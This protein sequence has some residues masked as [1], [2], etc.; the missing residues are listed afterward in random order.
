M[1]IVFILQVLQTSPYHQVPIECNA[2]YKNQKSLSYTPTLLSPPY[3][4]LG[5]AFHQQSPIA[6]LTLTPSPLSHRHLLSSTILRSSQTSSTR[7]RLYQI[8]PRPKTTL[9]LEE[10][11]KPSA[12]LTTSPKHATSCCG[13]EKFAACAVEHCVSA[14]AMSAIQV[15]TSQASTPLRSWISWRE[16]SK[17]LRAESMSLDRELSAGSGSA[18]A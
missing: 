13:L 3:K 7:R 10:L 17:L 14:G 2:R 12:A 16:D 6:T 18:Q 9:I 8:S 1:L 15:A 5:A 11:T 4:C